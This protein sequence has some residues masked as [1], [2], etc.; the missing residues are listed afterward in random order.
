MTWKHIISF[1]LL[2]PNFFFVVYISD[3]HSKLKYSL[4]L[5][6]VLI[7][8][9]FYPERIKMYVIVQNSTHV[10]VIKYPLVLIYFIF[11]AKLS[12]ELWSR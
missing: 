10:Y 3:S 1:R 12:D 7:G 4:C 2:Q 9:R 6:H 5:Q 11:A 8:E